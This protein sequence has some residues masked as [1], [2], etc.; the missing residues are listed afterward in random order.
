MSEA[1][2]NIL[3]ADD[4]DALQ[5]LITAALGDDYAI[6]SVCNANQCMN[7]LQQTNTIPDV[8]LLDVGMPGTN[9]F[10]ICKGIRKS[11]R[12]HDM[13][14]MFI[15]GTHGTDAKLEGY[16]A[17]GD[18]YLTKPID[19]AELRAKVRKKIYVKAK[20]QKNIDLKTDHAK[21]CMDFALSHPII[22]VWE[23]NRDSGMMEWDERMAELYQ[24]PSKSVIADWKDWLNLISGEDREQVEKQFSEYQQGGDPGVI[25]FK[26]CL[27]N[28]LTRHIECRGSHYYDQDGVWHSTI[29]TNRDVTEQVVAEIA[30]KQKT[31]LATKALQAKTDFIACMSHEIRT[32]M[33]G[34]LG[35]I[36][37]LSRTHLDEQQ[38]EQLA[39]AKQCGDNLV[40]IMNDILDFSKLGASNVS[41]EQIEFD[42]VKAV[43]GVV[44]SIEGLAEEKS[45]GFT[46]SIELNQAHIVR[47]DP[48]RIKQ[49]L[50]NLLENAIKFTDSGFVKFGLSIE[51]NDEYT[52]WVNFSILDTGIG[53]PEDKLG[54]IFQMFTQV[55]SSATRRFGGT[56]LGLAIVKGLVE[57]MSGTIAVSSTPDKGSHFTGKILVDSVAQQ[58]ADENGFYGDASPFEDRK[59][60]LVEDLK[61]NQVVTEMLLEE[62]GLDVDIAD[63]GKVAL[64][65]LTEDPTY[66]LIL[67]DCEMPVLDGLRA[68]EQIRAGVV[69]ECYRSIP[70]IAL[71][72]NVTLSNKRRALS[73]G[74]NGYMNKP[75]SLDKLMSG[76]KPYFLPGI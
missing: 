65:M 41:L 46:F 11:S 21:W 71:T 13:A 22:G 9:G 74:M 75:V 16:E 59:V 49:I 7:Y 17:G 69:G 51:P 67:M 73:V 48:I 60:L 2:P 34:V 4:D 58:S 23:A 26:I 68:T 24:L 28:G 61:V 39:L 15:S 76:I 64:D 62:L 54:H 66:D 52:E 3:V 18:D 19:L 36:D 8:L 29:G 10:D 45:I 70:I 38:R 6:E 27:Q 32:P 5:R 33:N 72:A 37:A 14:I 31:K 57:K 47:S 40:A 1:R 43:F 42:L 56:G 55:D 25:Q 35:I 53:I 63:N 30:L 12:F 44:E 20:H 50:T